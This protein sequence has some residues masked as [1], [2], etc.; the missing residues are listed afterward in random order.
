MYRPNSPRDDSEDDERKA[1]RQATYKRHIE[2]FG[3]SCADSVQVIASDK[4]SFAFRKVYQ[5]N[6]ANEAYNTPHLLPPDCRLMTEDEY[7]A[8]SDNEH[9]ICGVC[10]ASALHH[11]V[12]DR[13]EDTPVVLCNHDWMIV[14]PK[15]SGGYVV[16]NSI[17][18]KQTFGATQ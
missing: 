13:G 1:H 8:L 6:A 11:C 2:L 17:M 7:I 3:G 18:F 15:A 14:E 10:C 9:G 12:W 16:Y 5:F 4:K